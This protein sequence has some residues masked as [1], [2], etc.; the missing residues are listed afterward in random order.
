MSGV[1]IVTHG[2]AETVAAGRLLASLLAP[3]DVVGLSGQLGAGKS[4]LV[5]GVADGLGVRGPVPSPTF[6]LL[7]V[8]H[9]DLTL[10][11]FDLYR[12]E[13]AG[14][15][16]DIDFFETVEAGEGVSMIEWA[17]RFP[18]ELP[19]ER[20][21]IVMRVT[22]E[23]ERELAVRPLGERARRVAEAWLASWEAGR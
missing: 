4:C 10:Y 19:E 8:H 7:L 14:Q 15:L 3:G 13:R 16:E 5:R 6:N 2:E 22:G 23:A 17:D 18:S 12:L 21:E 20:L 11:H 1:T 9:A